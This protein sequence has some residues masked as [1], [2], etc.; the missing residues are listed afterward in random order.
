MTRRAIALLCVILASPAVVRF[1]GQTSGPDARRHAWET[2]INGPAAVHTAAS[3]GEAQ[4][5]PATIRLGSDLPPVA[6]QPLA[7]Q[8]RRLEVALAFLGQPLSQ[9]VRDA[10]NRAYTS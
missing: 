5:N 1:V 6:I 8:I 3:M 10:I 4:S 2:G 9:N 7:L